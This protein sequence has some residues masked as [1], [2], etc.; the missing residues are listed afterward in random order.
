MRRAALL[1]LAALALAA[2]AAAGASTPTGGQ[3]TAGPEPAVAHVRALLAKAQGGEAAGGGEGARGRPE[4]SLTT[5]SGYRVQVFGEGQNV[6]LAVS[7]DGGL[8]ATTYVVRGTAA[9]GRLQARFG[10]LGAI[11]MRF[12]PAP[13]KDGAGSC[14]GGS[15]TR[16]RRG[17]FVGRLHFRGEGGYLGLDVQRARGTVTVPS[18]CNRRGA[19]ALAARAQGESESG[20]LERSPE[21]A[22]LRAY[23]RE[24][25][26]AVS[27]VAA[28]FGP[29]EAFYVV[30]TL[31]GEGRMAILRSALAGP[32][33]RF[34]VSNALSSAEVDP[35]APFPGAGRFRENA[36]G[37]QSWS[38]RLA[39][40]FPG[41][42]RFPLTGIPYDGHRPYQLEVDRTANPF[43][44]LFLL[45]G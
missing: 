25:G 44:L 36:H 5:R 37:E 9:G 13:G 6:V 45:L 42:P 43:L 29:G 33:K 2:P 12:R 39:V 26:T 30:D 14:P 20:R 41:Y 38:G 8:V 31:S 15:S 16:L 1:A 11:S 18:G 22:Y 27:F 3:L 24:A 40:D 19:R 34:A 7:H 4:L 32:G 28:E 17:V 21:A 35:P 10:D 23:W